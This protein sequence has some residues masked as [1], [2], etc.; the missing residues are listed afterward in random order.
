M[1]ISD[2]S[3]DVCSSDLVDK[4]PSLPRLLMRR[5]ARSGLPVLLPVFVLASCASGMPMTAT[6]VSSTARLTEEAATSPPHEPDAITA[7]LERAAA[8]AGEVGGQGSPYDLA[9]GLLEAERLAEAL[10][11]YD[12]RLTADPHD[13]RAL[14]GRGVVLDLMGRHGEAQEAYRAAQIGRAACR[15]RVCQYV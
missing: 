8:A 15:E 12:E 4:T 5:V 7:A 11:I 6:E 10:A 13:A 3:S 1:R 9:R 14:D 2:W